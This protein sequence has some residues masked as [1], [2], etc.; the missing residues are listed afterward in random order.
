MQAMAYNTQHMAQM[1]GNM[2]IPQA[3][4]PAMVDPVIERKRQNLALLKRYPQMISLSV[5]D[6]RH[7]V[8]VFKEFI[9]DDQ[10]YDAFYMA[11]LLF[12]MEVS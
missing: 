9:S 11:D 7:N 8:G 6:F 10:A 5:K 1:H 12:V 3:Y 4:A 2:M